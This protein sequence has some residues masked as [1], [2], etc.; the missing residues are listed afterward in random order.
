MLAGPVPNVAAQARLDAANVLSMAT[1]PDHPMQRRYLIEA[2][3][4]PWRSE[5]A[6]V[7]TVDG[8]EA[9]YLHDVARQSLASGRKADALNLQ[10]RA[11]AA[12]PRDP[13]IAGF[14]AYLHLEQSP[15]QPETAR[16]LALHALAMSGYRRSVRYEDWNTFAVASAL[17]GREADATRAFMVELG[18]SGDADRTCRAAL[19]AYAVHGDRLRAPVEALLH[20][21][22]SAPEPPPCAWMTFRL[23][24][25]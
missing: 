10:M 20:R 16:Q 12:N 11:F 7:S 2:V 17:T 23:A 22:R 21:L 18:L 6:S 5:R 8:N 19:R 4:V 1:V 9:R 3:Q 24:A 14:L 13:D 25:S 15:S